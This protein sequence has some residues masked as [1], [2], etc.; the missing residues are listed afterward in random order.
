MEG[1]ACVLSP[2]HQGRCPPSSEVR[3]APKEVEASGPG[4][5]LVITSFKE[6]AKE[7]EPSGVTKTNEG[8]NSNAPQETVRS[9]GDALVSHAKGPVPLV[10]PLQSVPLGE[11][12]KDLETSPVQLSEVGAK[13]RS[14]E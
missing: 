1:R 11:G 6:P 4:A 12:S 14:K 9:I 8:Q 3:D 10:E 7:N 5:A 2:C 13:T